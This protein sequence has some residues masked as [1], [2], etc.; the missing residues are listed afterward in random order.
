VAEVRKQIDQLPKLDRAV[1]LLWLHGKN[2]SDLLAT[3]DELVKACN[4]IGPDKLLDVLRGK[5]P[6]DD[7]DLCSRSAM[8]W[9]VLEHARVVLRPKDADALLAIDLAE[10]VPEKFIA[11][12]Q[13]QPKRSREILEAGWNACANSRRAD[14]AVARWRLVP[15]QH[16]DFIVDWFYEVQPV[17]VFPHN[18]A[19]FLTKLLDKPQPRDHKLLG[20][21][22]RDK[23]F[24]TLD[25]Q[26]LETMAYL[27]NDWEK[28][29]A[30][31][32]E[33]LR[34]AWHPLGQGHFERIGE[35]EAAKQY[36]KETKELLARLQR[37]RDVL[38]KHFAKP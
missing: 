22:V 1:T 27:V 32:A 20:A 9:F 10:F 16:V 7:P 37:W 23:R 6:S 14:L 4:V 13:L 35:T 2:G 34:K 19:R 15:E 33:D 5:V 30:I 26:S 24:K 31:A 8:R 28:K 11:A 12:A 21:L 29:P 38:R 17:L 36:P 18:R 3:D 25:W